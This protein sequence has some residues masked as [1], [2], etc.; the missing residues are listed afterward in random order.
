MS[1]EKSLKTLNDENIGG[2][3][4]HLHSR[5]SSVTTSWGVDW[6][7][8]YIA[9]DIMQ[10]FFDANRDHLTEIQVLVEGS[11][12]TISAP[13]AFELVRLFY[14]GSEK[15][16]EDIGQYGEG[17]KAAAVCLLRDH[18][19]EPIAISGDQVVYL[20]VDSEKI[21]GTELQPVV[22]DFFR[23]NHC[24]KGTSLILRGCSKNLIH[25][26]EAGLTHFFYDE[27]RLLGPKL[28]ASWDGLFAIYGSKSA[29]GHIFYRRL[30]RG[31]IPDIP[32]VL[33]IHKTFDRI[34]KKIRADRDRNA[35]GESLMEIF[36]QIFARSGIK[37]DQC[38]QK[39]LVIAARNSWVRGHSLLRE[40]AET[41]RYGGLWPPVV[42][43]EV[44]GEQFYARSISESPGQ[45]L[46]YE[47]VE[48]RWREQGRQALAGYFRRF[49][50]ANAKDYC[51]AL[52]RKAHEE[53]KAKH[54]RM[55]TNA[56]T[57]SL[58]ILVEIIRDLAPAIMRIFSERATTYS[59][60]ETEIILGELKEKRSYHVREVF[61]SSRVFVADFPEALAVFLHEHTHIVGYDGSRGFTDALTELIEMVVRER[62]NLDEYEGEWNRAREGVI[63]E[64]SE[65]AV[66]GEK[67]LL[68]DALAAMDETQLRE[69]VKR[70]PACTVRRALNGCDTDD[71]ES[72]ARP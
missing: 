1:W 22:Y 28:W 42:A 67:W 20:R 45:A 52:K 44:F 4:T 24:Y 55:P 12:V 9:R 37:S 62:K 65:G 57:A 2:N 36:Y 35:F 63:R 32:V 49:G 18:G 17:F 71:A 3:L 68:D 16:D 56:E 33:V 60:A 59:I 23:S 19:I 69:L 58:K 54:H 14:L 30:K 47:N 5:T 7:E 15:G 8:T 46:E 50:V 66:E 26:L 72:A 10:N 11:T 70:L 27:N 29:S 34:E 64:R 31:D 13:T 25:A 39:T 53:A 6:N 48:H 43:K 51:E 21:A 41:G 61:F 40:I 38:G